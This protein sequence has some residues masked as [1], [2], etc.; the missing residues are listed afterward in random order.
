M[1]YPND[2]DPVGLR[3][4]AQVKTDLEAISPPNYRSAMREVLV[5]DGHAVTLGTL[6]GAFAVVYPESDDVLDTTTGMIRHSMQLSIVAGVRVMPSAGTWKD[7]LRW[8]LSDITQAFE[9][10]KQ[11]GG[12]AAYL[13]Q[14]SQEVYDAGASEAVAVCQARY[15]IEYRHAWDNPSIAT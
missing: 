6:S 15:R 13:T 5:W 2:G 12:N 3:C 4:I 10:D 11:L 9:A 8:L 14:T 7:D 1:A